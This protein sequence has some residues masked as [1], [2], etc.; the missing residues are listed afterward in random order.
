MQ[1]GIR[2]TRVSKGEAADDGPSALALMRGGDIDFVVNVAREY[3]PH[4]LPDGA[5]IRRLAVD[6]EIPLITDLMGARAIVRAAMAWPRERLEVLSWRSYL[7]P[8]A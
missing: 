6:L 5:L 3:D 8:R 4:G 7:R 2:C 1:E